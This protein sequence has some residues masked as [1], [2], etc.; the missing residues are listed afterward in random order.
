VTDRSFDAVLGELDP[1]MVVVTTAVDGERGGC[2][3]GFHAQ[4]SIEP[5]RYSLWISKANHTYGLVV[6]ATHVGLHFLA[7]GDRQL[8]EVFGTLSGDDVD[9]FERCQFEDGPFDVPVL[10]TC[11]NRVVAE[12]VSLIDEGGDHICLVTA[13]LEVTSDG[14]FEPL[15]LSAVDDLEPGHPADGSELADAAG[16][17]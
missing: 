9:K 16:D 5:R 7:A 8:A 13:P 15:R 10:T 3:V 6:R 14:P 1:A 4:S 12:R 17:G 2:L 11:A